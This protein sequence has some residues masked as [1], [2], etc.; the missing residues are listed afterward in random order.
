MKTNKIIFQSDRVYNYFKQDF[1]PASAVKHIPSWFS[2]ASRYH[3][4][5]KTGAHSNSF[6]E[7][8]KAFGFKSC[9][10]LMDSFSSGYMLLTPCDLTFIKT[11]NSLEVKTSPGYEEFCSKRNSM[12]EFVVPYG[13]NEE[14]FH[15][16]PNWAFSTPEGYSSLVM[17]PLN[18]FNLPF[19]TTGGII[20]SDTWD[21][22][23]FMPFFIRDGFEGTIPAGTPFA[24]V[25]PF[26]REEW[27]AEYN[28]NDQ[29]QI[30][31]RRS[32]NNELR[33]ATGGGVYR[34][35]YRKRKIYK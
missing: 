30:N 13:Y 18:H 5:K 3:I 29:N 28:Y 15:F 14:H 35:K 2:N 19:I 32:K 21:N 22:T 24:Q 9:P 16:W 8:Q 7:G 11:D 23:G 20:D 26:K 6:V 33:F 4:D 31:E 10:A 34:K 12:G 27:S 25:I 17:H 1:K